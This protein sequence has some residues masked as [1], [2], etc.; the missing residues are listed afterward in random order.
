MKKYYPVFRNS[1]FFE[2]IPEEK[3]PSILSCLNGQFRSF[4]RS[5]MLLNIGEKSQMAGLILLGTIEMTYLDENGNQ[6]NLNHLSSGQLFGADLACSQHDSLIQLQAL[7]D[8]EVLFFRFDN[9][10]ADTDIHCPHRLRVTSNLLRTFARQTEFLNLRLRIISQKKLRD[11]LK[12]YF[13]TLPM[14]EHGQLKLPF[15]R[16]ELAE[17]L[18][19]DRS[20]LSRELCRMR[21]DG[22]LSF[23]GNHICLLD[24][25]FLNM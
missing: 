22:L 16:H 13:R 1:S 21:D 11:K 2:G 19:A 10:L 5:Q 18:Y 24:K 15:T 4:H 25:A 8:C 6:I 9:L 3:Y 20:A 14:D 23:D 7:T 12:L 17:Y